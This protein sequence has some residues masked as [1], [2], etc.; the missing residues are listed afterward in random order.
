MKETSKSNFVFW[1]STL[2]KE[3][4]EKRKARKLL[5]SYTD[6]FWSVHL[7]DASL[8]KL[9]DDPEIIEI[10]PWAMFSTSTEVSSSLK[11]RLSA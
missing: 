3:R 9:F 5:V 6:K 10:V 8:E 2:E 7:S 11:L 1:V 4:R